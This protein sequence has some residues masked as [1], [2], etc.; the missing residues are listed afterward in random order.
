MKIDLSQYELHQPNDI[1]IINSNLKTIDIEVDDDHTFYII[2]ENNDLILSHN[3]DGNHIKG[4]ILNFFNNF[5]PELLKLPF[6]FEFITPILRASKG[7][8]VKYF[9]RLNEYDNWKKNNNTTGYIIKYFKGLGT[10]EPY[11]AKLFFKNIDKHLI[12]FNYTESEDTENLIDLAFNKKRPDDRKDWLLNYEPGVVIDKFS[13]KQT[14]KSFFNSEFIEFSMYDNIRSIPSIMDGLK[15][16]QRKILYGMF[17]KNHK[18][19]IKVNNLAG[20]IT[21]LTS[22]HHG[23]VSLEGTIVGMAQTFVG[24]NNINFLQPK[25]QFGTRLTGGKD[26]ASSRYIFTLLNDITRS[27]F[28]PEDDNILTYLDDDGFP[29]E[30]QWYCPILPVILLNANEGI[31]TGWSTNV[32]CFNP[33]EIIKY[34]AL[35]INKKPTKTLTPWYKG[36]NGQIVLDKEKNR[37][38]TRGVITKINMSTLKITEL[39]IGLWNDKFYDILDEL[40]E[41]KT[42]KDYTKNDTDEK[43]NITVSFSRE[44]LKRLE[45]NDPTFIK[46]FQLETYLNMNNMHL[47]NANGKIQKY[48]SVDEIIDDFYN[49]RLEYYQKRKDYLLEKLEYDRKI[50]LNKMKF[51]NHILKGELKIQNQK[52]QDIEDKLIELKID[53]IEDSYNYLLN[54][55]L[56]SLTSEKLLEFKEIYKKKKEEIDILTKTDIKEIWLK[57]LNDLY[58]KL[59]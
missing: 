5:F 46:T 17:K 4:L 8:V 29:I 23:N 33:I 36:F 53:K 28:I 16:S 1:K 56:L 11:E 27:I 58:K 19:E 3:C 26:A 34:L 14:Y 18:S 40:V 39:P 41:N 45:D 9:Y 59:K 35:K 38:N 54:M 57:D 31:G 43:V 52:R 48:E 21:S 47:F 15:P 12:Q 51:I 25:G 2:G 6:I 32:P 24:T 50:L 22:Y 42:I 37:Y 13:T 44:D 7:K 55:F 49:I 10:L 20:E 30:P